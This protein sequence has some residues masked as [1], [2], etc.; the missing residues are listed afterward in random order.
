M[1]SHYNRAPAKAYSLKPVLIG[2]ALVGGF[3]VF[4][5][6]Y[7]V[8][9]DGSWDILILRDLLTLPVC[10]AV[11]G[12]LIAAFYCLP[13][14]TR[15]SGLK[16]LCICLIFVVVLFASARIGNRIRM[17]AFASFADRSV[18]LVT[19]IKAYEQTHGKPPDSLDAL[20]PEFLSAIPHTGMGAY[21]NY[22]Y[23]VAEGAYRDGNPWT[24]VVHTP[25]G[26][27]DFDELFYYPLQNYP[28]YRWETNRVERIR[29]WAYLHE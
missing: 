6:Y 26:V 29:D 5:D 28:S 21:P 27:I 17:S 3:A 1:D 18:P 8:S 11:P 4:A 24:L 14:G 2:S 13:K 10:A 15:Q 12:I 7:A 22:Q 16:W 25:T 23:A 19:A 9:P 20:I